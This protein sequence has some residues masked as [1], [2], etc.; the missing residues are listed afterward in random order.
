MDIVAPVGEDGS[1][2]VRV[3]GQKVH[4]RE[5]ESDFCRHCRVKPEAF[6]NDTK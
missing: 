2:E 5:T 1:L 4:G 6:A 3:H